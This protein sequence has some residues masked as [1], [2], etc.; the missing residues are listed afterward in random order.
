MYSGALRT[1]LVVRRMVRKPLSIW[2]NYSPLNA[3]PEEV[4]FEL[5]DG[6][7]RR[8]GEFAY[9]AIELKVLAP[10]RIALMTPWGEALV[11]HKKAGPALILNGTELATLGGSILK[12]GFDLTFPDG[13]IMKFNHVKGGKND[14][15]YSE[16]SGQIVGVEEKGTLP[17]GTPIRSIQLSKDEIKMMPKEDRP[18]SVETRNY[19]QFRI[20]TS[21]TF[22]VDEDRI[23]KSLAI[24]ASFG[25][26]M[27]EVPSRG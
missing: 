4:K 12:R 18:R 10:T 11:T 1:A 5:L 22:P 24:F 7:E 2:S 6:N 19:R 26:L 8:V 15:Q 14:V 25:M 27:D 21:G 20:S 16:G 17:D 23:V 13:R 3:K 9:T